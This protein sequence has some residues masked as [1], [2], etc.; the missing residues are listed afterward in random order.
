MEEKF[1]YVLSSFHLLHAWDCSLLYG[2]ACFYQIYFGFQCSYSLYCIIWSGM[3]VNGVIRLFYH[4]NT[5]VFSCLNLEFEY[6]FA[7]LP[8][9]F[10][11]ITSMF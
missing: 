8:A 4:S 2:K 10:F 1:F 6:A 9:L 3:V 5:R 7:D 11:E